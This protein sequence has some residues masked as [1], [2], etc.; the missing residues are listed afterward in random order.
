M[1]QPLPSSSSRLRLLDERDQAAEPAVSIEHLGFASVRSL[2]I[3][4]RPNT[5]LRTLDVSETS[6]RRSGPEGSQVPPRVF[7]TSGKWLLPGQGKAWLWQDSYGTC[8][9]EEA[10]VEG[11][12]YRFCLLHLRDRAFPRS[13]MNWVLLG[14][15]AL[16]ERAFPS[17]GMNWVLLGITAL[18]E[19]ASPDRE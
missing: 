4:L 2:S 5:H 6:L 14:I 12:L 11:L 9:A 15:T 16:P 13:G 3:G 8:K 10:L 19:R 7:H 18:P 17:S 1:I